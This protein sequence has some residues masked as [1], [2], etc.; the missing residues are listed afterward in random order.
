M[1]LSRNKHTHRRTCEA[2]EITVRSVDCIDVV[3]LVVILCHKVKGT[4][5]LSAS[6]LTSAFQSTVISKSKV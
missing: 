5:D 3:F 2:G 1:K 4:L 6:F